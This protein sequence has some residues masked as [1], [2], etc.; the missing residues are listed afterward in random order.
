MKTIKTFYTIA[1]C[2][3]LFILT[4]CEQQPLDFKNKEDMQSVV[5]DYG[6]WNN[7]N[8]T[9]AQQ[10]DDKYLIDNVFVG[11]I[12][13]AGYDVDTTIYNWVSLYQS[14][15]MTPEEYN[16]MTLLIMVWKEQADYMKEQGYIKEDTYQ[17][18][19]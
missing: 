10:N 15:D 12:A 19:K 14:Q 2:L 8:L 17:L 13:D 7:S 18:L 16:S 4:S 5:A 1:I 9:I 3:S 6:F 11:P